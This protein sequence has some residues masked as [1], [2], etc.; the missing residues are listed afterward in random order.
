EA[1]SDTEEKFTDDMNA[2][3][4]EL[5]MRDTR[6]VNASGYGD[7]KSYT[8]AFDT[9][10]LCAELAKFDGLLGK[11]M[12][13]WRDVVRNGQTELVN[14]NRLVKDYE[15]I[16][17]FKA[18]FT[19]DSG[20]C[21]AIGAK[22]GNTTFIAVIFGAKDKEERFKTAKELLHKGFT[23]YQIT[24]PFFSGQYLKPLEVKRG[25]TH[26]VEIEANRLRSVVL[27]KNKTEDLTTVMVLPK[28]VTAPIKKG[29]ILGYVTFFVGDTF[30]YETPLTAKSDVTKQT[31]NN[32]F[33]TLLLNLLK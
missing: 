29:Q 26:A 23:E 19:E 22:R 25:T 17:G 20:A 33:K 7:E 6:Y 32:A 5:G 4:F 11:Y 14:E 13:S 28:Y 10:L 24:E 31:F 15:G 9:A 8:T 30:I 18:G 3:A 16:I 1:V 12:T 2:R 27:N 21:I